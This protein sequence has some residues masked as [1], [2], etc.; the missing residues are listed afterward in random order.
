MK[1]VTVDHKV[2]VDL[3]V[4]GVNQDLLDLQDREDQQEKVVHLD[5]L[6]HLDLQDHVVNQVLEETLVPGE[7][8]G[9]LEVQ[10]LV[11][12]GVNRD[13]QV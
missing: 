4:L 7:K 11:V 6:D 13:R 3:L 8:Q 9:L 12:R 5:Q 2:Q 10:D 1:L